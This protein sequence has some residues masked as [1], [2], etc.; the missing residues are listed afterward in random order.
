MTHRNRSI[1]LECCSQTDKVI[2]TMVIRSLDSQH[3]VLN[4]WL[5]ICNPLV[6]GTWGSGMG[7]FDSQSMGSYKHP[8]D[9]HGH[10]LSLVF[11]LFSCLQRRYR[12]S[13]P[14]TM[15]NAAQE[16][17]TSVSCNYNWLCVSHMM[18]V[19]VLRK[20]VKMQTEDIAN[21]PFSY[22]LHVTS[23]VHLERVSFGSVDRTSCI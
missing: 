14:D 13:D 3:D 11:E 7:S 15:T 4:L 6:W 9:I 1:Q 16:A 19:F 8:I 21:R 23:C 17:T 5:P 20:M 18:F 12:P 10:G 22:S 2:S